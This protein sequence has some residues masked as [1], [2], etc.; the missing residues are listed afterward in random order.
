MSMRNTATK[1]GSVSKTFHW[2]V[3]VLLV[4]QGILGLT[5]GDFARDTRMELTTLHKSI[6]ITILMVVVLRLLW[7]LYSRRPAFAP[8]VTPL[9]RNLAITVEVL[10]YVL[11]FAVPIAGWLMSDYGGRPV[12]W[13]GVFNLPQLVAENHDLHEVWEHRH[14]QLFWVL[15]LLATGHAGMA[16]YHQ[17]VQ[18]DDTL[19]RM[20]PK[21]WLRNPS[22]KKD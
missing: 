1:W 17:V 9:E 6:G 19:S 16:I 4:I 20:M 8:G 14:E 11:M 10:L 2:L 21:G 15:V 12:S 7:N 13:F 18:R 22:D 3:V 5:M